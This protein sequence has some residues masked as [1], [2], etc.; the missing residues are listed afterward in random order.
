M[1]TS[2]VSGKVLHQNSGTLFVILCMHKR[3][4]F[5]FGLTVDP[6]QLYAGARPPELSPVII[7][8][9][10]RADSLFHHFTNPLLQDELYLNLPFLGIYFRV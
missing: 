9:T 1:D 5:D 4:Q 7:D 10:L 2:T 8:Q 3:L 6:S